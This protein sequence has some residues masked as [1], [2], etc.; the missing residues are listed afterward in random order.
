M[1]SIYENM[2]QDFMSAIIFYS[3]F[4]VLECL[5]FC[6]KVYIGTLS[7]YAF[8]WNHKQSVTTQKRCG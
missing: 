8:F 5:V 6:M 7:I 2:L 4:F 3:C 1:K